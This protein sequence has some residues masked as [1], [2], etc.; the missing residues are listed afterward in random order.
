[1][2]TLVTDGAG[3]VGSFLVAAL[4]ARGD[5]VVVLREVAR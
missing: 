3:F 1:M 5:E 2:R 4:P